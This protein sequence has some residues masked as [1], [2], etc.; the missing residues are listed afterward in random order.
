M[1]RVLALIL[2]LAGCA[3]EPMQKPA[4][5]SAQVRAY[6]QSIELSGR[7]SLRYQRNHQ[8]EAVHGSF[9]WLQTPQD[10]TIT[11]TSPLGQTLAIIE[12]TPSRAILRRAEQPV[13]AADDADMLAADVLGWPL[14]L[15]GLRDWLQGFAVD[16]NGRRWSATPGAESKVVT[17]DGWQ[18]TYMSWQDDD[19]SPRRID[20]ARET[21]QAGQV[22]I[23]VVIDQW[24][25]R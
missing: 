25:P 18:I 16:H 4:Q 17:L 5:V 7:L 10:T 12:I 20:L 24:Q 2:A 22:A 21:R 23:R 8:E 11:L 19:A 6:Q 13:Q 1:I 15:A 14:P 3:V 9:S